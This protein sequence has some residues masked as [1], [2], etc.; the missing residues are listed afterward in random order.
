MDEACS[1]VSTSSPFGACHIPKPTLGIEAPVLSLKD[2][3]AAVG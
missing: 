3:G 2:V 1:I